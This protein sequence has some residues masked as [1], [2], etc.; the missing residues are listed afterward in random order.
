MPDGD[1]FDVSCFE[2]GPNVGG[3]VDWLKG[4]DESS[5]HEGL[6]SDAYLYTNT[7]TSNESAELA[8]QGVPEC[9]SEQQSPEGIQGDT[10][11]PE[12]TNVYNRQA[13][14]DWALENAEDQ[15]P[16]SASCTWFV[17]NALWQGGLAKT[18]EW[19]S[20]GTLG[21]PLHGDYQAYVENVQPLPGTQTAWNAEDLLS[22]LRNTYPDSTWENIDFSSNNNDPAD[23]QIGDL[24]FYNW[25]TG[26]GV[27]HVAIVT[28]I[29]PSG[30][31]DVTDWSTYEDDGTRP[32]PVEMRGVTYSAV[33]NTW[34][35]NRYPNVSAHLLHINTTGSPGNP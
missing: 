1:K 29:E 28:K 32:S 6:A 19:T 10:T 4:T 2:Q 34:L 31:L 7:D 26:E 23:A 27:S 30:Y 5:G 14:V 8:A 24:V 18:P 25:G 33:H 9:G 15:A 17:S 13:A 35:Q 21:G 22:Y 12:Q 20:D 3:Y 16:A 11:G